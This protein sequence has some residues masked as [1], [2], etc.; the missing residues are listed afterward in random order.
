MLLVV[1]NNLFRVESCQLLVY[2]G[3]Y[4]TNDWW[5]NMKE[6]RNDKL[7]EKSKKLYNDIIELKK[8]DVD[9]YYCANLLK[10]RE[11][12]PL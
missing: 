11:H 6:L 8:V 12:L 2:N 1:V 7:L 10:R 4:N 5:N 3:I 9:N